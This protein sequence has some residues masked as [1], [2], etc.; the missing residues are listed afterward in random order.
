M[1]SENRQDFVHPGWDEKEWVDVLRQ[2]QRNSHGFTNQTRW[3]QVAPDSLD[4]AAK[5]I[6]RYCQHLRL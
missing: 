3:N 2:W 1:T 6:H 4:H 5:K